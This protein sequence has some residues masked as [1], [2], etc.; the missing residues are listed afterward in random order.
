[1]NAIYGVTGVQETIVEQVEL[2]QLPAMPEVLTRLIQE[3]H[4]EKLNLTDLS[5]LILQDSAL[6]MKVLSVANSSFY[7]RQ[8]KDL[9]VGQSVILLGLKM[10][11]MIAVSAAMHQFLRDFS[12]LSPAA[13]ARFWKHALMTAYLSKSMAQVIA[14]PNPEEA[15]LAGLLHDIGQLALLA[16]KGGEY[17]KLL[18]AYPEG[19]D[20]V[21]QEKIAFGV[22]HGEIGAL[23]AEYWH[24]EPLIADA[25][26]HHHHSAAQIFN[27]TELVKLVNA[28]NVLC[29]MGQENNH[30][31][32]VVTRNLFGIPAEEAQRLH[33]EAKAKI[34]EIANDVDLHDAASD[35]HESPA[36]LNAATASQR[37]LQAEVHATTMLSLLQ[38]SLS[39]AATE[40]ELL[41]G[42][43]QAAHLLFEPREVLLFA[44]DATTN[45]ISGRPIG[46]QSDTLARIR[47]PLEPGRSLIADALLQNEMT[48]SFY[49][50]D[51]TLRSMIDQQ[52]LRISASQ[53]IYCVPLK[54]HMFVFGVLVLAYPTEVQQRTES[55]L[56]FLNAFANQTADAIYTLRKRLQ[57]AALDKA[58]QERTSQL[59]A[60]KTTH[61]ANNAL[62]ILKN[63]VATLDMK[64]ADNQLVAK[65]LKNINEEISRVTGIIRTFANPAEPQDMMSAGI[66]INSLLKDLVEVC[67][68]TMFTPAKIQ[69]ELQFDEHLP[70]VTGDADRIKQVF[71]NLFKNAA[72]AMPNGGELR[73]SSSLM[74][75]QQHAQN[76]LVSVADNGPGIPKEVLS[77]LFSPLQTTKGRENSGLGLSITAELLSTM[78]GAISCRSKSG[79]GT[80]FD[81]TLP[82]QRKTEQGEASA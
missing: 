16:S 24:L 33:A 63:Y 52:I 53:G 70:T 37:K 39:P 3:L 10:V 81:V 60:R 17:K 59:R 4:N 25:I 46:E 11:K 58:L 42:V 45:L 51:N 12:D 73:V 43:L 78:G 15:Y 8:S 5:A 41:G 66:Q 75:G 56:R 38:E 6:S 31:A 62:G 23:L 18:D 55:Q 14:Y 67:N 50:S 64:L 9:S 49:Q 21:E 34:V 74:V 7:N 79:I 57:N 65:E 28:A 35:Q 19:D 82:C 71:V 54:N 68:E 22:T 76:I 30:P 36:T 72:E 2:S 20:L 80:V 27:A 1:V 69:V 47:L 44:W 32:L 29:R 40:E 61:E 48:H 77:R 13:F 26:R